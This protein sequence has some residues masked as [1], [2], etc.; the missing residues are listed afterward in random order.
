MKEEWHS[1]AKYS[2]KAY[3]L[4]E[5]SSLKTLEKKSKKKKKP[6]NEKLETS[7]AY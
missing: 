6:T 5:E 2:L 7:E 3:S 4:L 1:N